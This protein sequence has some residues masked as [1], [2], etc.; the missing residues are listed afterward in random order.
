MLVEGS[1]TPA[2]GRLSRIRPRIATQKLAEWASV[3]QAAGKRSVI[4][5]IAINRERE[6]D[7]KEDKKQP[8]KIY[9]MHTFINKI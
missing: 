8:D 1:I 9:S 6:M 4:A 2:P 5:K 7:R 3:Q